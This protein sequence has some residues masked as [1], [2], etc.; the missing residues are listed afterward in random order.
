MIRRCFLSAIFLAL[1]ICFA[2]G[3][4]QEKAQGEQGQPAQQQEPAQKLPVPLPVYMIEDKA[5]AEAREHREAESRQHEI[6]DLAAQ[7]GMNAATQAINEATQRMALYTLWS[8]VFVGIGTGLLIITLYLTRQANSAA[9]AAAKVARDALGAER[10]WM[11]ILGSTAVTMT[12]SHVD[13]TFFEKAFGVAI[14]WQNDGRSPAVKV[15]LVITHQTVDAENSIPKFDAP[16]EYISSAI[17]G[18]GRQISTKIIGITP[19]Q[20][21]ALMERKQFMYLYTRIEYEDVFAIGTTRNTEACQLCVFLKKGDGSSFS[22]DLSPRG[23][24]N[25]AN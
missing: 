9:Q 20:F 2:S 23:P 22:V 18:P 12:D 21:D 24:Q 11:N 25:S 5:A 10:A 4:T 17:V 15:N 3:Q 7:R 14:R 19:D 1:M 8:T 6:D 13:E 16:I